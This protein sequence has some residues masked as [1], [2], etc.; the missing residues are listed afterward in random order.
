MSI[1]DLEAVE[2]EWQDPV[3]AKYKN[4]LIN[5]PPPPAEAFQFPLTMRILD[6]LDISSLEYL[7]VDHLDR[8]LR[9]IRVAAGIRILNNNRSP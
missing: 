2:P 7:G 3:S 1:A 8:V 6:G 4:L 5:V 9:S